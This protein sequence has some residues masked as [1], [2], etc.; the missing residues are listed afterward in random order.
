M[1]MGIPEQMDIRP[2]DT[3]A[4]LSG[5]VDVESGRGP[6]KGNNVG[7]VSKIGRCENVKFTRNF[8]FPGF[9]HSFFEEN[10]RPLGPKEIEAMRG[11]GIFNREVKRNWDHG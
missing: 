6:F 1:A 9:L 7:T 10:I 2:P 4:A 3:K 8:D 5:W 11:E